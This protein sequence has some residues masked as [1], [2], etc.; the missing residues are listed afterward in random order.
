VATRTPFRPGARHAAC[1]AEEATEE[2]QAEKPKP[3][4]PK[5]KKPKPKK[6]GRGKK[7]PNPDKP[8]R[9]PKGRKPQKPLR[10]PRREA[11]SGV[12][13]RPCRK[14]RDES[15][16]LDCWL[17]QFPCVADAIAWERTDAGGGSEVVAWPDWSPSMKSE[18]RD[19]WMEARAWHASGM[20]QFDGPAFAD[21]PPN[22]DVAV[23]G[24]PHFRTVLDG[25]T[26]AW[27]LYL[28]QVGHSLAAEIEGWVHWSIRGLSDENLAHLLA[29]PK[30]FVRDRDDGG[31]SD[32]VHPGGYVIGGTDGMEKATPSHPTYVYK[33]L[34]DHDMV[35]HSPLETVGRVL[36]WCRTNMLHYQ[37]PFTPD[38]AEAHWQYRGLPPV[39]RV[40]EGTILGQ[41]GF[42]TPKHWTGGCWGTSAFLRSVLRA[43]NIP[44]LLRWRCGHTLPF[45]AGIGR[46]LSHGD[47]PY[48]ALAKAGYPAKN[49]LIV[50]STFD[51]WFPFN[52]D[53]PDNAEDQ[54]K[55]CRNVGRRTVDLAVWN[56]SP[57]LL[58]KYCAD[59]SAGLSHA[60]G[61][62]FAIFA[63]KGYTVAQLEATNLWERLEAEVLAQ[64]IC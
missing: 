52:P 34:L 50:Q 20:T 48:N 35:G 3:K 31:G 1:E 63:D 46:Y 5:P 27:P 18:L 14:L 39:R 21:P 23:Q 32:S 36:D 10:K 12:I 43:V 16:L 57:Y 54:A 25:P 61:E 8:G 51:Q 44:V 37:G 45:F 42:M 58:G 29:G 59:K 26:Q 33:F 49:L 6:P 60:A 19:A 53:D 56:F 2:A 4:K 13:P 17:K 40:I 15:K 55:R 64:G 9:K 24:A 28:A 41:P 47:D 7:K 30:R 38:N 22:Q 62:V 11:R